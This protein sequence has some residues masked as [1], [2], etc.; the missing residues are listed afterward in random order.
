MKTSKDTISNP[1]ILIYQSEEDYDTISSYLTLYGFEVIT[2]NKDNI[3]SKITKCDYD[4]CILDHY[5]SATI[6]DL[7]LLKFLRKVYKSIPVIMISD[8][9]R[10]QF[11][12]E[13]YNK[14]VDDYIIKP[15]NLEVLVCKINVI[16]K[17]YGVKV[18]T[19]QDIYQL[20]DYKFDVLTDTLTINGS[21]TKLPPKEAQLL[22]LLCA[23]NG[24]VLQ[25]NI[26]MQKLWRGEYNYYSKR[27]LDVNICHLRNY[28]KLDKRISIMTKRALG[29]SLVIQE[30]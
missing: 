2:S 6:G 8:L 27:S 9:S 10:Y 26:I 29:Y 1:R 16:L 17:R 18:K 13:A 4:L 25:T 12:I 21:E 3:I 20:G 22:A 5:K 15:Y 23:Y 7:Y 24:E 11:I 30:E 19:I 14:G 28:F